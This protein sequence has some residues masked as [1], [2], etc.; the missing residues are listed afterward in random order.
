[1]QLAVNMVNERRKIPVV[2]PA[3]L[4]NMQYAWIMRLTGFSRQAIYKQFMYV[5]LE[6][7]RKHVTVADYCSYFD[8]DLPAMVAFIN[9]EFQQ[10]ITMPLPFPQE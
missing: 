5:R 6:F 2:G 10:R 9:K 1:M 7:G 4:I 3:D 8:H